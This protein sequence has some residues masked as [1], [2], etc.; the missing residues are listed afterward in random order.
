LVAFFVLTMIVLARITRDL[1]SRILRR[2]ESSRS[3]PFISL[4]CYEI[5]DIDHHESAQPLRALA[6]Q[7]LRLAFLSALGDR[8]GDS[9]GERGRFDPESG[10]PRWRFLSP[11]PTL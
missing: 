8:Q 7:R 9:R 11:E 3:R 2:R 10:L 5:L 4:R 6:G 1:S